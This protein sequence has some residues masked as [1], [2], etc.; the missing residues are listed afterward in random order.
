[1]LFLLNIWKR[2]IEW[3]NLIL[4]Y[5]FADATLAPKILKTMFIVRTGD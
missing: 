3:K 2:G 4:Q 1:M 5:P